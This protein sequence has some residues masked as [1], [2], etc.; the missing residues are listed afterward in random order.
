MGR[1]C[2]HKRRNEGSANYSLA[3]RKRAKKYPGIS[4]L[5]AFDPA[6][7]SHCPEPTQSQ[8]MRESGGAFSRAQLPGHSEREG[9]V[10]LKV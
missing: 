1:S 3:V 4:A 8:R 2:G 5:L 9:R 6:G 10:D 7:A